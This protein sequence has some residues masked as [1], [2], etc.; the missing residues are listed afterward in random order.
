MRLAERRPFLGKDKLPL[1]FV[2][3]RHSR[4]LMSDA[5]NVLNYARL[6]VVSLFDQ[7]G[8]VLHLFGGSLLR[9]LSCCVMSRNGEGQR[10]S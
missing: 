3:A 7:E 5:Q 2:R 9:F 4:D 6:L 1:V 10:E 8:V